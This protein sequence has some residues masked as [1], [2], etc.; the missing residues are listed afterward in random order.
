[1]GV[2]R[3]LLLALILSA[4]GGPAST[5]VAATA[6]PAASPALASPPP[7]VTETADKV[8]HRTRR[9]DRIAIRQLSAAE[10]ASSQLAGRTVGDVWAVAIVGEIAPNMGVMARPNSP[11]GIWFMGTDG[12]IVSTADSSL[13]GCAPY[14]ADSLVPPSAPVRCGSEPDGYSVFDRF[15]FSA[16]VPGPLSLTTTRDDRWTLPTTA[17][18]TFLYEA[19]EDS[20]TYW[21]TYCRPARVTVV[22]RSSDAVMLAGLGSPAVAPV[23]G[24][25]QIWLKDAHALGASATS[26]GIVSV[27]VEPR[28]GF[29][30]VSFDWRALAPSGGYVKFR[31]VDRSGTE[32]VRYAVGNGP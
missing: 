30:I 2:I 28:R 5:R 14:F 26:D 23:A 11:C 31:F 32:V 15:Q 16:T 3:L 13:R 7:A 24:L 17:P 12:V 20:V 19:P 1:M 27:T 25:A 6:S 10:I 21:E 22:A 9:V 4:C 29:E 18:G 8:R